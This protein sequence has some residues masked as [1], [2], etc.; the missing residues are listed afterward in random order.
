M[1]FSQRIKP[2]SPAEG[3]FRTMGNENPW[4]PPDFSRPDSGKS[5][6]I[7]AIFSHL[8]SRQG[9]EDLA[10]RISRYWISALEAVWAEKAEGIKQKDMAYDAG[11]PLSRI[12]QKTVLIS[13]A[14][15][16]QS[17]GEATLATLEKF[18][19]AHFPAIRGL[20]LL[21]ACD[22]SDSRFNDGGFSQITRNNI[23]APYGTN[24][25]F[26]SMMEKFYSMADFVLNHVDMENPRFQQFLK[27]DDRA[28]ECFF[29]FSEEEYRARLA[30]GDFDQIFRPR[31]FPLFTLFRRH[32][33]GIHGDQTHEEKVSAINQKFEE[34]GLAPIPFAVIDILSIFH[35][36]INDQMLLDND[37]AYIAGF[38]EFLAARTDI[39]PDDL[40]VVSDTQETRHT[41]FIFSKDI[42]KTKD[43]LLRLLPAMGL[44]AGD[45][46]LYAGIYQGCDTAIF[47]EPVRVLT[48]FSHVQV[49]L[50]TTTFEGLKFL[51][52]DFSWYLKMD[53]NMLRLDAANFAF[54]KWGT[55]CFGLPEGGQLL[56]ILYL[57]MDMVSP[58]IVP[59]LE[60]NAPLSSILKQMADKQAPPPMMY[61]FHLAS[62][63]PVVFNSADAR[64]LLEID[65]M[66]SR[67]DI[68]HDRI[69]FS[70]DESH[71]GKS[72]N[73][74]GGADPLLTYEQRRHFIQVVRENNAYVKYKSA[75][76][77]QFPFSEFK[78]VCVEANLEPKGAAR[79]L[80]RDFTE[81]AQ[82]LKLKASIHT[83]AHIAR[84]L[85]ISTHQ[86]EQNSALDFFVTKII[87]GKEPYELCV[88]TR[89]ALTKLD[90]PAVEVKRYL[91][92]KTLSFAL[93]G[94]HVKSIYFNDLMGLPN[95][96]DRVRETGELRN[97]KRKKSIRQS[98]E[99]T[100]GNLSCVESWI[101]KNINNTIALV[102]SDP[103]FNPRGNQGRLV[104]DPCQSSVALVQNQYKNHNTLVVVNVANSTTQVD[105][106]LSDY[107]L[108]SRKALLDHL[109]GKVIPIPSGNDTLSL[110]AGPFDRFWLKSG[111][112][113][114]DQTLCVKAD[115]EEKM[116]AMIK[117]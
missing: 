113:H 52:D 116:Q 83:P 77:R 96:T 117:G 93:M 112:I 36:I 101:A 45:A 29:V 27:G 104:V 28:G 56:K 58:R 38:R 78:K 50:N 89:D 105:I 107:G 5:G 51:I 25:Q 70:L 54:K 57:S 13:Y 32:P 82:L 66:V 41:P 10:D 20:H 59:N 109:T 15:S 18:L 16:V 26:E 88:S 35:K 60:V 92:F 4:K 102:D 6:E 85:G 73:G 94:R 81:D 61:D 91:A 76:K 62:M 40:F 12:Q 3:F 74:S 11:D 48:T 80:F 67:Y 71:D 49:D 79:A 37:V 44:N 97:I 84:A 8:F 111:E 63:L 21:P 19:A 72:V 2:G 95:D 31:P 110:A 106:R 17:K 68:A 22:I 64:P 98:L 55:S 14:D 86:L 87:A 23:H 42:Q 103:S 9:N 100:L 34:Q 90:D 33:G 75:P 115:S 7:K 65:K 43:L 24:K 108:D 46:G 39:H 1:L 114:I 53:L 47:G 99:Q 69:R 30:R